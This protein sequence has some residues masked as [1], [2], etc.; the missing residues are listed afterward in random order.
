MSLVFDL[1]QKGHNI[2]TFVYFN[3]LT[4]ELE[5]TYFIYQL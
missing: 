2:N 4:M 1:E 3:F 5:K